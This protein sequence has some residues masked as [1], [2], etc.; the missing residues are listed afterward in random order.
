MTNYQLCSTPPD[1]PGLFEVQR[2]DARGEPFDLP[3]IMRFD[4]VEFIN[5]FGTP[6]LP[7]DVWRDVR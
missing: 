5:R 6:V 3:E 2:M 4:G 7:G 1:R